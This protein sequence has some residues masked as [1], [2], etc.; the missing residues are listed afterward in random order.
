MTWNQRGHGYDAYTWLYR[1]GTQIHY[2]YQRLYGSTSTYHAQT[3]SRIFF[4]DV[5]NYFNIKFNSNY[6]AWYANDTTLEVEFIGL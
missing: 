5:N 6:N 1:S 2:S 3:G 4:F